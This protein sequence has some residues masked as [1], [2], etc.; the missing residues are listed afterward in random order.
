M[1]YAH[2]VLLA[3]ATIALSVC[4]A[5]C[6]QVDRGGPSVVG[7]PT[8][9]VDTTSATSTGVPLAET[10]ITLDPV[11]QGFDAPLFA[12][13]A[14]DGSGRL[15]IVEQPGR[16]WVVRDGKRLPGPFLD[17]SDRISTGG[18]RG[19][20]GLAFAPPQSGQP[21]LWVNYTDKNGDTKVSSFAWS[22]N[23]ANKHSERVW[24]SVKQPFPNHNGGMLAFGPDNYLYI[25]LGDGGSG[26]DPLGNAQN[27]G[28]LL[29]KILRI[30]VLNGASAG[31][32]PYGIPSD[33]PLRDRSGARPEI[34]A[35]GLR[36]PW[37]FSFD[38]QTGDLWIGDVGQDA[39]EE[40]DF[41]AAGDPGGENYGWNL[42]EGSHP[43]SPNAPSD[44]AGFTMPVVEYDHSV[45]ESITGGYVYRG[46]AQPELNGIYFFADFVSGKV[47]GLQ[48]DADGKIVTKLLLTTSHSISSFAQ[49]DAGELYLTDLNGG[50]YRIVVVR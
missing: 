40:I 24:L 10:T 8:A 11:A 7:T 45:G 43:Y 30:D 4:A 3:T 22:G 12:T 38:R 15:F 41:Q 1:R 18:E 44:T 21:L 2:A 33:N 42:F 49:D 48:R 37:R 26:G 23:R 5:S 14:G 35:Y 36:N 28:V 6:T 20:L 32:E 13:G 34:W 19:L 31:A 16:I 39:W 25:G 46:T 29:G 47:W 50:L 9:S 27:T 17:L